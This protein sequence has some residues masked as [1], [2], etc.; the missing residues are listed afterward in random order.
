MDHSH[1]LLS[2]QISAI[3]VDAGDSKSGHDTYTVMASLLLSISPGPHEIGSLEIGSFQV[4]TF[5]KMLTD[6]NWMY[7]LSTIHCL[8]MVNRAR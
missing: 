1:C 6:K 5:Q 2:T 7:L 3:K 4:L 8:D